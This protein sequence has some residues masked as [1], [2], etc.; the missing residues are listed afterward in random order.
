MSI[1]PPLARDFEFDPAL[2]D[3]LST[4]QERLASHFECPVTY[5]L[6][7]ISPKWSVPI[8]YELHLHSDPVRFNALERALA[9]V[10]QKE[11]SKRLRELEN[12]GVIE[13]TIYP[14]VPP[15]VEYALTESGRAM[16][17]LLNGLTQWTIKYGQGSEYAVHSE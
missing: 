2:S 1:Q 12:M 14:E 16:V 4:L 7:V 9:P 10:T 11:L 5:A 17:A 3:V 15:R 8:L 6:N 13:R